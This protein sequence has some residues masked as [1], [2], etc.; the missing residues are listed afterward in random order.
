MGILSLCLWI[1]HG[2]TTLSPLSNCITLIRP[3]NLQSINGNDSHTAFILQT[4][5]AHTAA[6]LFSACE[7]FVSSG[8]SCPL[9]YSI[10]AGDCIFRLC[11]FLLALCVHPHLRLDGLLPDGQLLLDYIA[12]A[13]S[14][15]IPVCSVLIPHL[16]YQ[17]TT[18][19]DRNSST[20][21]QQSNLPLLLLT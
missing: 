21:K 9:C 18:T 5:I 19:S 13:A 11:L 1:R 12:I 10:S 17:S 4:C 6:P 14:P 8:R 16:Q 2:Y 15:S 7:E 3:E 20:N